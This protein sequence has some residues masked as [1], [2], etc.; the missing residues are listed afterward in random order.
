MI[1]FLLNVAEREDAMVS[2]K[3]KTEAFNRDWRD[4]PLKWED[5]LLDSMELRKKCNELNQSIEDFTYEFRRLTVEGY[6]KSDEP[7]L[8]KHESSF[9]KSSFRQPVSNAFINLVHGYH[10][11]VNRTSFTIQF[12]FDK[13]VFRIPIDEIDYHRIDRVLGL[14]DE[15]SHILDVITNTETFLITDDRFKHGRK[16]VRFIDKGIIMTS[17]SVIDQ[18]ALIHDQQVICT[19]VPRKM[20]LK[21]MIDYD[22]IPNLHV[23]CAYCHAL[24]KDYTFTVCR[25]QKV[26]YCDAS[27]RVLHLK[28]GHSKKCNFTLITL[29]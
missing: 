29:K 26:V 8:W 12:D 27:C 24:N 2:L 5:C 28:E 21:T 11:F 13:R 20:L 16:L 18:Y 15:A 1:S 9:I 4:D 7:F 22:L 10:F 6:C 19:Q 14:T 23:L 25:C 3:A 17:T